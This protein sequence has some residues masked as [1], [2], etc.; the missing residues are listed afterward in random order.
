MKKIFLLFVS[1]FM[2]GCMA[3]GETGKVV[4]VT[5]SEFVEKIYDYEKNPDKWVYK[6]NKPAIV[7]F[8]ADWCGPCRRLSPVLEILAA[9]YK[10]QIVIYKVNTDKERELAA[11]FGITSLP[12]LVFIP[13]DGQPQASQG[14]LPEEILEKGIKEV[15]LK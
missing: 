15:L 8:Y 11:A 2:I 10:D 5:K 7:D 3:Y 4:H 6:G 12:T 13:V 1:V 14:A 9:K